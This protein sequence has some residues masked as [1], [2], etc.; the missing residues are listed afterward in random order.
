MVVAC[1]PGPACRA[2]E[3]EPSQK[4]TVAEP[5]DRREQQEENGFDH[6]SCGKACRSAKCPPQLGLG[7]HVDRGGDLRRKPHR[8][9]TEQQ[10]PTEVGA[11]HGG[12]IARARRRCAAQ[13][14]QQDPGRRAEKH[15]E[16]DRQLKPA[17]RRKSRQEQKAPILQV[18]L[19]PSQIAADELDQGGRIFL[20]S[21]R[22][23]GKH[24]DFVA[25][26][27]HQHR[28]DLI[29]AENVSAQGPAFGQRRDVTMGREGLQAQH[30]IVPPMGAAVGL[31]PGAAG[32]VGP[33]GEPHAELKDAGEG[34]GR[35]HADH[36]ALEDADLRRGLHD[37]HHAQDGGRRNEAVGVEGH[38]EVMRRAPAQAEIPDIAGLEAGIVVTPA[39]RDRD[40]AAPFLGEVR[41]AALLS[42]R[43]DEV[44]CVAQRIEMKM[45]ADRGEAVKH[46]REIADDPRGVFI[47]DAGQQGNRCGDRLVATNALRCR[48]DGRDRVPGEPQD[49]KPDGGVPESDDGPGQGD[50]EQ[51]QQH[52]V[53]EAQAV[54]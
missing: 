29:M 11:Q 30:R 19:A 22:L 3:Q 40:A 23:V 46:G 51:R 33:H 26:A 18:A 53:E 34:R 31:P 27:A 39:I 16:R 49:Q 25:G 35:R 47:A 6:Q 8:E 28:L 44:A 42:R 7:Q 4:Q 20:P 52:D 32:G 5:Q 48:R 10:H 41:K 54:R 1:L 13:E 2:T 21:E 17:D 50:E 45:R 15:Q 36:E 43:Y 38:G 24:A 37:A 14:Q 9:Q 12:G